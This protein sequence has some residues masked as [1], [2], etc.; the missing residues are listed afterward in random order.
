MTRLLRSSRLMM[1]PGMLGNR[2]AALVAFESLPDLLVEVE[3]Y[4]IAQRLDGGDQSADG[5]AAG[6]C[7]STEKAMQKCIRVNVTVLSMARLLVQSRI[8]LATRRVWSRSSNV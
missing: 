6:Q 1:Q 7:V 4:R 3:T 8:V 5:D 2:G